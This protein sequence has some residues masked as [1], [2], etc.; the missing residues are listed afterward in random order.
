MVHIACQLY[1]VLR[2]IDTS[3]DCQRGFYHQR[4]VQHIGV[5]LAVEQLQFDVKPVVP[6]FRDTFLPVRLLLLFSLQR[7][8]VISRQVLHLVGQRLELDVSFNEGMDEVTFNLHHTISLASNVGIYSEFLHQEGVLWSDGQKTVNQY[9]THQV[10]GRVTTEVC[11]QVCRVF[12]TFTTFRQLKFMRTEMTYLHFYIRTRPLVDDVC[13][14][15]SLEADVRVI[16][17]QQSFVSIRSDDT[18][19]R[20]VL[21]LVSVVFEGREDAFH[22]HLRYIVPDITIKVE[23]HSHISQLGIFA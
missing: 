6:L 22:I 17:C 4:Y 9:I 19:H 2:S 16:Q 7:G 3:I 11:F 1:A 5:E 18:I 14:S 20:N 13:M 23:Y 12:H 10:V 8:K 21:V 15:V